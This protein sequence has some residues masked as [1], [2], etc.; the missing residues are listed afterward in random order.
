MVNGLVA[1]MRQMQAQMQGL[2]RHILQVR[3]DVSWGGR[4]DVEFRSISPRSPI[5]PMLGFGGGGSVGLYATS[6]LIDAAEPG[7]VPSCQC[8]WRGGGRLCM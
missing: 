5:C 2:Q 7:F 6:L 8:R 4:L 3:A 1:N